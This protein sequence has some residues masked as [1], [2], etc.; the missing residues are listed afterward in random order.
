MVFATTAFAADPNQKRGFNAN[1][2]FQTGDIDHVNVFNGNVALTI[3]LGQPYQAGPLIQYQFMLTYNSKIW[4]Y[5]IDREGPRTI[6]N[7]ETGA[8]CDLRYGIPEPTSTAGFG[9][10]L[11]L[12]RLLLPRD[13]EP[14]RGWTYVGP[15]GAEHGFG[16][17]IDP[18]S[19]PT[20]SMTIVR[21]RTT[22]SSHLELRR[23]DPAAPEI[24]FPD[25]HIR[26]FDADGRL[27]EIR[28]RYGNWVKVDYSDPT[29]WRITDG[30]G[31]DTNITR[32]HWVHLLDKAGLYPE[33]QPNF[34]S[35][36]ASV[37][38]AAFDN[39]PED[40]N[41]PRAVYQFT[42]EDRWVGR[43]GDGMR[44]GSVPSLCIT[45]PFLRSVALPDGTTY[46]PNYKVIDGAVPGPPPDGPC[47][48]DT[49][50]L[51][52]VLPSDSGIVQS[53]Q[54]PTGGSIE[55]T[56]GLYPMNQSEC[57]NGV[58]FAASYVG[59]RAR[60][61]KDR[62]GAELMKWTYTPT[63]VPTNVMVTL[64][65]ENQYGWIPAP[66]HEFY[67][68]V[69]IWSGPAASG[70]RKLRTR[71][72]FSAYPQGAYS[73]VTSDS[74][75]RGDDYGRPFT[76]N[77]LIGLS[78][79]GTLR[80]LSSEVADCTS[81]CDTLRKSYVLYE[82][83]T[84]TGQ[85]FTKANHRL[86]AGR[87][88]DL[89]A[90]GCS[91][92]EC[93]T[94]TKHSDWDGFG[95]YRKSVAT[96]NYPGTPTRTTYTN[97]TPD[98]ANW[99]LNLY[100]TSWVM[101]SPAPLTLG[102][103]TIASKSIAEFDA[104]YGVMK[105]LRTLRATGPDPDALITGSGDLLAAWCRD[106]RGFVTSE[107]Y[108]GGDGISI[109]S[110]P[111]T[112]A[113]TAGNFYINHDYTFAGAA[114]T[115]H[116][117]KYDG[118]SHWIADE[119]L[120]RNTGQVRAE[121]DSAGV[122]TV[123][124]FDLS[125]R[126]TAV[127][128]HGRAA[129]TY[130]YLPASDPPQIT[131][132]QECPTGA[133]ASPCT[134]DMLTE[135]RYYYDDLGR[136]AQAMNLFG[137]TTEWA[138]TWTTYDGAGRKKTI[139]VPVQTTGTASAQPVNTPVTTWTYDVLGRPLSE[140][141]PDSNTSTWTYRGSRETDRYVGGEKRSTETSNGFGQL[142]EVKQKADPAQGDI[143]TSYSYD[144]GG[145]LTSVSMKAPDGVLQSRKFDYD[146]RA[147]LRW[148][149][150]PESGM[151]SYTYDS[152]GH[153]LTKDQSAASSRFDLQYTY[154]AAERLL[155]LS[156]RN[157]KYGQSGEPQF[158]VM[159]NFAYGADNGVNDLR[160]GKL[161]K[162]T[163]YNYAS[164]NDIVLDTYKIE[165]TYKYGDASGRKTLRTT[166]IAMSEQGWGDWWVYKSIDTGAT[167]NALDLPANVQYPTCLNCG[168][169]DVA[170]DRSTTNYSYQ[171]GRLKSI[172]GF[173]SDVSYWPNGLR[174]LLVHTNGRTDQ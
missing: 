7:S 72:Y 68:D 90:S 124:A 26:T 120:D 164:P 21:A 1:D 95:H 89:K 39:T 59:V 147:F 62:N 148:E 174:N 157:P 134:A 168:F 65:C 73:N 11:S 77:N 122:Q 63:L 48:A 45:A 110:N 25:G 24:L 14:T 55:W 47:V 127:R 128:P 149:S 99:L 92:G 69:E 141:R 119:D 79:V 91:G 153:V 4:D 104:T 70:G 27:K 13:V 34:R 135:A 9:W 101:L 136:P 142:T 98:V 166:T 5:K 117:A 23:N 49:G 140:T 160:N 96:S 111:C 57:Q 103:T 29:K 38:L 100:T 86:V 58:G 2:V 35:L 51:N 107:R 155:T 19:P 84:V 108:V 123:F 163:R 46:Q 116:Q 150:Q 121:R 60:T 28:D 43:G 50:D 132:G 138:S 112:A 102:G 125:G 85:G 151:A 6:C 129:T 81:A 145:R 118:T 152:R 17:I 61:F 93:Y 131:V 15:D 137:A 52:S 126:P 54:L 44:E 87:S 41:D 3:P 172:A 64:T 167:Y 97:Y 22:D 159:K 18:P 66:A 146:G 40:S 165:D 143:V 130:T 109:P 161:V 32:T 10:T 173:V 33:D 115:K 94:D 144:I 158:R 78:S 56:H 16:H 76:R 36:V 170:P 67:N 12:G 31:P 30:F 75:F 80:L 83:D 71:N 171:R 88:V 105:S 82:E 162:A 106:S 133:G 113:R 139:S 169:P 74:I 20:D 37:D 53:M 42:Y 8:L 114:V 156:A 154:D